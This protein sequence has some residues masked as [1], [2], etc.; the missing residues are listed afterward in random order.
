MTTAAEEPPGSIG[1]ARS[2][3][4]HHL[5]VQW[6]K[7]L[8]REEFSG[9]SRRRGVVTQEEVAWASG[10]TTSWYG[11][12]ERGN[13]G[14]AFSDTVLDNVAC[15]LKLSDSERRA[16]Y[17]LVTRREPAPMPRVAAGVS[18]AVRAILDVLPWP[19][20]IVDAAWDLV[21]ANEATFEWLPGLAGE[22]NLMRLVMC[23]R[24]WR[25]QFP[26]WERT[27]APRM[28]AL[29]RAQLAK[30]PGAEQIQRL[31]ADVLIVD[32]VARL[33]DNHDQAMVWMHED[34]DQRAFRLPGQPQ[35]VMA[36]VVSLTLQ[37]NP[38][39]RLTLLVPP[40]THTMT[41]A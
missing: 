33:W 4:L 6:R 1:L 36:E 26:G 16:L 25:D 12:L 7:R 41:T 27:H 19:A 5:M 20:F 3:E 22:P 37:R 21:A 31:K 24:Q 11:A 15:T 39:L 18:V 32:D 2:L 29:L 35:P 10:V 8:R 34:G 28:L 40:R 38:D 17:L 9:L 14:R 13:L 30:T 23:R